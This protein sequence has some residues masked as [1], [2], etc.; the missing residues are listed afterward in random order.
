MI[1]FTEPYLIQTKISGNR[2]PKSPF[3]QQWGM[4]TTRRVSEKNLD[5]SDT[6]HVAYGA[7]EFNAAL[8]IEV[9]VKGLSGDL[10]LFGT[11]R[12][13]EVRTNVDLWRF[14]LV[15]VEFMLHPTKPNLVKGAS[16]DVLQRFQIDTDGIDLSSIV[17]EKYPNIHSYINQPFLYQQTRKEWGK[18]VSPASEYVGAALLEEVYEDRSFLVRTQEGNAEGYDIISESK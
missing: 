7:D 12:L 1:N 10:N 14:S 17:K 4:E 16:A 9:P 5:R 11:R 8:F 3:S 6:G 2:T 18:L 13:F 15:P